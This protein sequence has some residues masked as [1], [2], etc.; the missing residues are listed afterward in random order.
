MSS[1]IALAIIRN[2]NFVT[3]KEILDF[4]FGNYQS[5]LHVFGTIGKVL[6]RLFTWSLNFSSII[7]STVKSLF[8]AALLIV[9]AP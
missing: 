7:C 8:V 1:F 5:D 9:A 2:Y 6:K 4:V 3:E